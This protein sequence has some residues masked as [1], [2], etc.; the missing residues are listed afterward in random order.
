LA[1]IADNWASMR[2]LL[3]G[4]EFDGS[5]PYLKPQG[6]IRVRWW[7]LGWV[8]IADDRSGNYLCL[9]L[10]PSQGGSTGQLID[11]DHERGPTKVIATGLREYL[12]RFAA[13]LEAGRIEFGRY[14][15]LRRVG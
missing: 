14:G 13:D 3:E 8:P 2:D 12:G 7:D 6:P 10:D 11:W 15:D 9:D 1:E 5:D 4:G